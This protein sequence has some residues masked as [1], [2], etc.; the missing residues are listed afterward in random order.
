MVIEKAFRERISAGE[1]IELLRSKTGN[2]MD[3]NSRL[4]IFFK[5]LLYLARKTF[6]HNF[7]ALTR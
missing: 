1:M 4:S 2:R 5:V 7:A 6:S 3:I